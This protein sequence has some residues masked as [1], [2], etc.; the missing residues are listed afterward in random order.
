[1]TMV[2]LRERATERRSETRELTMPSMVEAN[3][4][5][6]VRFARNHDRGLMVPFRE[7][8]LPNPTR[9]MTGLGKGGADLVG[10]VTV[11]WDDL[12]IGRV[13][14]IEY[15]WVDGKPKPEQE[16]W[17]DAVRRLGGFA[18]WIAAKNTEDAIEQTLMAI[19]RCRGMHHS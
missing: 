2:R 15:K 8:A 7:I 1:M 19:R 4:L 12:R 11:D 9:I 17:L 5:P 14:A 10:I 16:A 18:T 6:G 13:A 3:R